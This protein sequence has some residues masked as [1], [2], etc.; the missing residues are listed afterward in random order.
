M[1]PVA[2]SPLEPDS[3]EAMLLSAYQQGVF[4]M[5]DPET[6]EIEWFCPNP[7]A[8]LD[9]SPGGFH[10][11]RSLARVLR[12]RTFEFTTDEDFE[13]VMR[14]CAAS[15][16]RFPAREQSWIDERLIRVYT[17]VHRAGHAHSIEAWREHAG[18]RTLVGGIYGVSIGAAFFAES[19]FCRPQSGGT[20][21]S[22]ACLAVL[23]EHLRERG[24]TVLDVQF[25]N[26]HLEQFGLH[27]VSRASFLTQLAT[28]TAHAATWGTLQ[29]G[30]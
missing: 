16:P 30:G 2:P 26:R 8:V 12:R 23:V 13:G 7:R 17:N 28:A 24:F 4:P 27:L 19:K 15:N 11:P 18:R 1:P 3:P 14:G 9:V 10:V 29:R 20:D 5:A 21:A 22:K 25:P 6:G